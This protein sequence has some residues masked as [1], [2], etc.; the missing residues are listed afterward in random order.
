MNSLRSK[1]PALMNKSYFNYG[2]Q[3]PLPSPSLEAI[4]ESW[5]KIQELGPFT[6]DVWPYITKEVIKDVVG[7]KIY[8]FRV[9]EDLTT[10]KASF[11]L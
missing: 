5:Q 6:N 4:K 1:M 2:G 8:Y 3:G 11:N 10:I 7:Q 9:R